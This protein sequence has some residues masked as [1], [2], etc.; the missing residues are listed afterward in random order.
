MDAVDEPT[1]GEIV[2][3]ESPDGG[4]SVEVVVGQETVWLTQAQMAELFGRDQSVVARHVTDAFKDGEVARETSMQFLHRSQG[5]GRPTALYNLDVIISV[6]YRV[7]SQRG[8]QFRRWATG[9]LKEHLLT[10]YTL[11]QQRLERRGIDYQNAVRLMAQ[12]IRREG[13]LTG[14]GAELINVIERFTRSWRLLEAYDAGA[15]PDVS[16]PPEEPPGV[17]LAEAQAA[18]RGMQADIAKRGGSVGLVGAE[19]Q[20]GI[21]ESILSS[22]EQ[23]AFGELAYPNIEDRA[24][25]LLYFVIKDHP[26]SDGNKRIASLLFLDYLRKSGRLFLDDGT[27]RVSNDE[28]V[29][30]ALLIAE[31][32]SAQKDLV[33][34]LVRT[35]LTGLPDQ[36]A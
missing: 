27:T 33:I 28:V 22:L 11:N 29:A 13:L 2:V 15:F 35:M 10:G 5:R 6:G 25:H 36:T 21:L 16:R 12:T 20:A 4:P 19:R 1:Q 31:S 9:V 24:A 32:A 7:K 3:F 17:T 34:A 14:A 8:V 23:S 18:I 26:F 30:L